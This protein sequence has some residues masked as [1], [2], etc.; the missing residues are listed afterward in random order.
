MVS[1]FCRYNP[2]DVRRILRRAAALSAP[3]SVL[4]ASVVNRASVARAKRG[5][6]GSAKATWRGFGCKLKTCLA[7]H[8]LKDAS[9]FKIVKRWN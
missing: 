3:G 4:V 2:A 9:G 5:P 6:E 8:G 7:R 1:T